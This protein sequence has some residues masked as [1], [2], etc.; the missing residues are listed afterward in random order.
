MAGFE[1]VVV[2]RDL[3]GTAD[4]HLVTSEPT[5]LVT[6]SVGNYNTRR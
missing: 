4:V 1:H 2:K 6:C 3:G 5:R